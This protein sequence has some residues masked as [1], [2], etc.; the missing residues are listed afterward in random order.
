MTLI[1]GRSLVG[2][3]AMATSVEGKQAGEQRSKR[4]RGAAAEGEREF[5]REEG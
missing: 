4:V 3:K 5:E 2:H 1:T